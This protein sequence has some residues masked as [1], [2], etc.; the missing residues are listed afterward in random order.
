MWVPT[1]DLL[2]D[3]L[4]RGI[5]TSTTTVLG[6]VSIGLG[7][8]AMTPTVN[9]VLADIDEA[10]FD[11]Y[12]KKLGGFA[13]TAHIGPGNLSIIQG[14]TNV[15]VPDD[16]TTV[17]TIH[18]QFMVKAGGAVLYAV[19]VFNAPIPLPSPAYE[20]TVIERFGLDPAA[21]YGLSIAAP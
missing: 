13:G 7:K 4:E 21:N 20:L 19:E 6:N 14:A 18:Y 8:S 12:L 15:W 17:N 11:G 2:E 5:G 3:L 9:T 1:R 10:N 16:T